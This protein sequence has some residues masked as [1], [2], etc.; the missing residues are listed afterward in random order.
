MQSRSALSARSHAPVHPYFSGRIPR[1][2]GVYAFVRGNTGRHAD[3]GYSVY[4]LTRSVG[5]GG[6]LV[7]RRL[8]VNRN[9]YVCSRPTPIRRM[10]GKWSQRI[11]GV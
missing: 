6:P 5:R 1:Q 3:G 11:A 8:D 2:P 4:R 9:F 10:T 7:G